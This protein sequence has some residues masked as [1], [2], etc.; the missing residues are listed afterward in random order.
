[1]KKISLLLTLVISGFIFSAC[2][3]TKT[4][5]VVVTPTPASR[6]LE[7]KEEE[8]PYVSI[9]PSSDGHWLTL[10][11]TKINSQIKKIDYDLVYTAADAGME[12]EKGAGGTFDV[13]GSSAERKILLGTES[14]TSGCKY[15]YDNGVTGGNL[16]LTLSTSSGQVATLEV[17]Y[18]LRLGS[19][20]K[21]S[22]TIDLPATSYSTKISAKSGEVYIL[23]KNPLVYSL[24]ASTGLIKDIPLT[25]STP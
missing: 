7:L 20:L 13:V 16:T 11:I 2:G 17:P 24:F 4:Q 21:K 8:K 23:L 14:C 18:S 15:K 5:I 12:I 3:Q 1:M 19:S 6:L 22:G 10:K 25:E 9:I